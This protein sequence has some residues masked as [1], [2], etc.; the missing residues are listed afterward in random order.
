ME[1]CL[2]PSGQ[3]EFQADEAILNQL[4]DVK[5]MIGV[6]HEQVG[7]ALRALDIVRYY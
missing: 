7:S 4:K 3:R 1:R 6:V 2:L 5:G